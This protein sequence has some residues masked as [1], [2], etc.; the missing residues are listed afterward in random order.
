M[1]VGE[2]SARRALLV[3]TGR[4]RKSIRLTKVTTN[5]FSIGSQTPYSAFHNQGAG[6]IPKRE[7]L[8]KNVGL[9]RRLM[10]MIKAK[11]L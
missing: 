4:L 3:Q 7:F 6:M 10:R 8:G 11:T 1:V 5:S 2:R 9:N